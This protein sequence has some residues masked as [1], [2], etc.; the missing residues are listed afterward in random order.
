MKENRNL[1]TWW[2]RNNNLY[3]LSSLKFHRLLVIIIKIVLINLDRMMALYNQLSKNKINFIYLRTQYSQDLNQEEK[4]SSKL[5]KLPRKQSLYQSRIIYNQIN[6]SKVFLHL[7]NTNIN[8]NNMKS[9]NPEI[10]KQNK[11]NKLSQA[12]QEKKIIRII[13]INSCNLVTINQNL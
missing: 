8:Q 5:N 2:S 13:R 4:Y 3:Q 10:L 12:Q 1:L 7:W 9:F 11:I 6:S